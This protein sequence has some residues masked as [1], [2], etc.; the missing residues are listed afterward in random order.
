MG[1]AGGS[2]KTSS[3]SYRGSTDPPAIFITASNCPFPSFPGLFGPELDQGHFRIHV[4]KGRNDRHADRHLVG[5]AAD[6]IGGDMRTFFEFN[7]GDDVGHLIGKGRVR[8]SLGNGVGIQRAL[9]GYENL[10]EVGG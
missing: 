9:A 7:N 6:Q 2:K 8:R 1:A 4:L 5:L 10:D 3:K